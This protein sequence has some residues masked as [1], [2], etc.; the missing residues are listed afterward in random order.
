MTTDQI[1][2]LADSLDRLANALIEKEDAEK[3]LREILER[4]RHAVVKGNSVENSTNK[5]TAVSRQH[6]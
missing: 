5:D 3:R 1:L 6:R 4:R 2:S